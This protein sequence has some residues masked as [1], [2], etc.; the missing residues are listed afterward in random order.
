MF[1]FNIIFIS[2]VHG[3]GKSHFCSQVEKI[4]RLPTFSASQLIRDVKNSAVDINKKVIDAEE[5]Q[6]YL[7]AALNNI[8][9]TSKTIII[10]GHFCLFNDNGIFN[11]PE[12]TFQKMP[13]K[14]IFV[15]YDNPEKI[16]QRIKNRD[17]VALS[18]DI[19]SELQHREIERAEFIAN[20]INLPFNKINFCDIDSFLANNRMFSDTAFHD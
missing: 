14:S 8:K 9:T 20:L 15:L 1:N 19:I 11:I 7:I 16:Y 6:D 3:V 2:G 17:D 12:T 4:F 5:N 18:V 13:L 10:D